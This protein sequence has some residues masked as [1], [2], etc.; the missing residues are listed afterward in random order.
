MSAPVRTQSR[1]PR[2][3]RHRCDEVVI[4]RPIGALDRLL[5]EELRDLVLSARAPVVIDMDECVLVDPAAVRRIALGWDL[6]RPDMCMVCRAAAARELLVRAGVYQ[7]VAVFEAIDLAVRTR[8]QQHGRWSP[9][10]PNGAGSAS[11]E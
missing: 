4:L 9:V 2:I 5:V 7:Y 8:R 1:E 10:S 11:M 3:D 6:Y